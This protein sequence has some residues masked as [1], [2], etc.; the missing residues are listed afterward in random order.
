MKKSKQHTEDQQTCGKQ[1]TI[2]TGKNS[3]NTGES[4]NE[5]Y[6]KKKN[7]YKLY[8]NQVAVIR[9]E[10]KVRKTHIRKW[11]DRDA[12]CKKQ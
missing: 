5:E 7:T 2:L 1:S 3:L 9:V 11:Y 12:H 8:K 4:R 10:Q 6:I